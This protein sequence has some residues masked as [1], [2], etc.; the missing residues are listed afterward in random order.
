MG[1]YG[2]KLVYNIRPIRAHSYGMVPV[3]D[4]GAGVQ[5]ARAPGAARGDGAR[6]RGR[7]RA[8]RHE[9][10]RRLLPARL[11][12]HAPGAPPRARA[13]PPAPLRALALLAHQPA[14][15]QARV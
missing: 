9:D 1:C 12:L 10:A 2:K 11:A 14:P 3:C 8:P 13:A 7:G 15:G 4:D 6:R 5:A